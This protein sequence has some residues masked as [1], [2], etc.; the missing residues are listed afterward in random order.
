MAHDAWQ[1]YKLYLDP[2]K[3]GDTV[4]CWSLGSPAEFCFGGK[5]W[6]AMHG[7]LMAWTHESQEVH[8]I[9]GAGG[10]RMTW[11]KGLDAEEYYE[12][13]RCKG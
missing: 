4:L 8:G 6:R 5:M 1:P 9:I 12:N 7:A 2:I 3:H 13:R 11:G 10:S